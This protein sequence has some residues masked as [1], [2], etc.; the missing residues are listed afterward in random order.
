MEISWGTG[1]ARLSVVHED[2]FRLRICRE[3][4]GRDVSW[5]IE[6]K[7]PEAESLP[8]KDGEFYARSS[9]GTFVVNSADQ[10]WALRDARSREIL[11]GRNVGYQEERGSLRVHLNER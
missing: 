7:V 2:V 5:A 1:R 4:F 6:E 3:R 9:Q 8:M 10:T 11:S